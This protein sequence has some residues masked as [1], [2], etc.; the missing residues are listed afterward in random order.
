MLPKALPQV[1]PEQTQN[2][3][4]LEEELKDI[5]SELSSEDKVAKIL[6]VA[7][8]HHRSGN[9]QSARNWYAQFALDYPNSSEKQVALLGLALIDAT[10]EYP[11][12]GRS[13][14][15]NWKAFQTKNP[16]FYQH[17]KIRHFKSL[18]SRKEC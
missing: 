13:N 1:T 7:E 5:N 14:W 10:V 12:I 11:N 17:I 16:T 18:L 8:L 15:E 6:R 2:I 4:Q 9:L 3:Q